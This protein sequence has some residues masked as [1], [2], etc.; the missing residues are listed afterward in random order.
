[1]EH[2]QVITSHVFAEFQILKKEIASK[3]GNYVSLF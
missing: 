1:M 3:S 2:V